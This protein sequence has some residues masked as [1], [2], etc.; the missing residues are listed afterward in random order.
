MIQT[1]GSWQHVSAA[2]RPKPEYIYIYIYIHIYIYT[3]NVTQRDGFR[4][5]KRQSYFL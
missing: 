4:K 1:S 2:L 5:V 3:Y